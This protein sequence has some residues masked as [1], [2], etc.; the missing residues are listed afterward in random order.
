M[1]KYTLRLFILFHASKPR[2]VIST[3]FSKISHLSN[4]INTHQKLKIC[5]FVYNKYRINTL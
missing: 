1:I 3:T 5:I 4:Q 2:S